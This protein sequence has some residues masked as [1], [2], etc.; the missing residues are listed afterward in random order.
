MISNS[1]FLNQKY[2]LS[3]VE[4]VFKKVYTYEQLISFTEYAQTINRDLTV[5]LHKL[6]GDLKKLNLDSN[7][8][9]GFGISNLFTFTP[10]K[11]MKNLT[12][13]DFRYKINY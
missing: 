10:S 1:N 2:G 8:N 12:Q 7:L 13:M 11:K 9:S 5:L 3:S 6:K 4:C